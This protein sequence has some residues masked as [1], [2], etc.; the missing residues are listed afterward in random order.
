MGEGELDRSID[1]PSEDEIGVLAAEFNRLAARLRDLQ[2]SDYWRMLIEQ[3]KSDAVIDSTSEADRLK[4]EFISVASRK[5]REPLHSLR[6]ALYT[7]AEGR[8]GELND[9][10]RDTLTSARE[11]AEQLD[12]IMIDLL[13]LAEIESGAR[14]P[15]LEPLRPI[16]VARTAIERHRSWAESKHITLENNVWP[17]LPRITADKRAVERILDN[18][19]SNA[20]RHT[21]RDGH[22]TVSAEARGNRVVFSVRDTGEGI[23]KEHL[24]T[25]FGRFVHVEGS[26]GGGTGLGL[27]LVKRLVEAQGGQVSVESRKGE[28]STFSFTLPAAGSTIDQ[29]DESASTD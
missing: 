16:D 14:Q 26:S 17:D 3:K 29:P 25:I 24:P 9:Q 12:E 6:L 19:L 11:N 4:T 21:D 22:V 1:I 28:G 5:L 27:A 8:V 18:L 15:S 20:V 23:P 7:V 10:Q 2:R 13:E